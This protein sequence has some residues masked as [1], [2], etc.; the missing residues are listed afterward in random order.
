MINVVTVWDSRPSRLEDQC[1]PS[2]YALAQV[3]SMRA[4]FRKHLTV[5]H[6]F[7]CFTDQPTA[8]RE[9]CTSD[10][11][12]IPLRKDWGGWWS[13]IEIFS[14]VWHDQAL[15]CD[16]DNVL[17]GNVDQ[18]A[19]NTEDETFMAARDWDYPIFNSSLMRFRGDYR[20]IFEAFARDP[21]GNANKHQTIPCLG[22][23][24]FIASVLDRRGITP[25][26]WQNALPGFFKSRR[27]VAAGRLD[28]SPMVL[29]HGRLKPWQ[30]SSH[31]P[32]PGGSDNERV[33]R[34]SLGLL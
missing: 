10:D 27:D 29:W 2:D 12:V 20:P 19:E 7:V 8:V 13:K 16:L 21:Q 28:D 26:F 9:I 18:L 5:K 3:E 34:A 30:F 4:Q 15:Y 11:M 1:D 33:R 23:Q 32:A 31:D 14:W 24:S 25:A 22:D 6:R 17:M